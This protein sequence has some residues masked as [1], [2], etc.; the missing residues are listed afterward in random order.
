MYLLILNTQRNMSTPLPLG[1]MIK[2]L[3]HTARESGDPGQFFSKPA[4]N[5]N[6]RMLLNSN[7]VCTPLITDMR[8]TDYFHFR[9]PI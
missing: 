8:H 7:Q 1:G 3:S 4:K 2:T 6:D 5:K 9:F